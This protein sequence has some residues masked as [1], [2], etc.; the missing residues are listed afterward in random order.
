[1]Y[2]FTEWNQLEVGFVVM[3]AILTLIKHIL[4][5]LQY[6]NAIY[7][8]AKPVQAWGMTSSACYFDAVDDYVPFPNATPGRLDEFSCAHLG[9]WQIPSWEIMVQSAEKG[10]LRDGHKM[11]VADGGDLYMP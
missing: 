1:M 11:M 5:P 9:D 2:G 8:A 10:I 7:R 3:E 6:P 4:K